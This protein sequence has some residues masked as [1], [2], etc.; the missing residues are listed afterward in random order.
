MKMSQEAT[1]RGNEVEAKLIGQGQGNRLGVAG[2]VY[3]IKA[4]GKDTGGAYA[5][6]EML[7]PPQ[8]GAP[9]HLHSR[10]VESFYILEGSLSFWVAD[11]KVTGEA[12]SLVIAPPGVPHTFKNKGDT[13]ARAL[14]LITPPGVG[15]VFRRNRPI[16]ERRVG[17]PSGVYV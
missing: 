17:R 3:T 1:N 11:Q 8:S 2:G 9:P 13:P 15:K 5:L 7:V 14:L 12:G 6:I 16:P 4:T 10:E